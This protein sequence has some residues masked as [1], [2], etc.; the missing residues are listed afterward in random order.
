MVI[1]FLVFQDSSGLISLMADQ[2]RRPQVVDT[3]TVFPYTLSSVCY[4]VLVLVLPFLMMAVIAHVRQKSK[5][6]FNLL[7]FP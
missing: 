6:S 1:P 3:S 5:G 4:L 2:S 7:P